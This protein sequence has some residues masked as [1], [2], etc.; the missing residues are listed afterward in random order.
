[1]IM[2]NVTDIKDIK[3]EQNNILP[4]NSPNPFSSETTIKVVLP[5]SE[6]ISL[7]IYN[8]N[9]QLV[10]QLFTGYANQGINSFTW[11]GS[12]NNN[13]ELSTGTY[14]YKLETSN[15]IFINK[16]LYIRP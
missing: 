14:Y 11:N 5:Q 4:Q 8:I 16:L 9:G 2:L 1:N 13:N 12:T 7:N 10:K 3:I 15:D 6:N